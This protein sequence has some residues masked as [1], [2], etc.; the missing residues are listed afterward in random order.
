MLF[1]HFDGVRTG[2][3]YGNYSYQPRVGAVAEKNGPNTVARTSILRPK[4]GYTTPEMDKHI[5]VSVLFL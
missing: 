3:H 1:K 5:L 4:C 2:Q